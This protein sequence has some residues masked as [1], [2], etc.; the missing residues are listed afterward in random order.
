MKSLACFVWI[1]FI[2]AGLNSYIII[3]QDGGLLLETKI[4]RIFF[5][6]ECTQAE[7]QDSYEDSFE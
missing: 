5:T 1:R 6:S 7:F 2:L 4:D 3:K